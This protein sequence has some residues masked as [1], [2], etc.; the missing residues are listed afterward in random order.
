V[1]HRSVEVKGTAGQ[2]TRLVINVPPRYMESLQVSVLWPTWEWIQAPETRWLCAS[3]SESLS[4]K[5]SLDRRTVL[6]SAWYQERFGD[7]VQ[8]TVDQNE[9]TEYRNRRGG[10]MV[11]PSVGGSAT[12]KGGNRIVVD[13]PHNPL[14][15]ERDAQRQQ[16]IDFFLGTRSTRLDDKRRGAIVVVM[17]R[18]HHRDLAAVCRDHGYTVVRLPAECETPT[19]IVFPRSGR[20]V[21]RAVGDLLWPARE[22]APEIAAQ[23]AALGASAYAGQYQ[24]RPSPRGGGL[25]KRESWRFYAEGPVLDRRAQSWD[26]AFKGGDTHDCVVG[27]AAGQRGADVYL[28]DRFKAHA[29]FQR[30]C[31]AIQAW[32]DRYPGA[33]YRRQGQWA[34]GDRH[35][36]PRRAGPHRGGSGGRHVFAR[37]RGRAAGRGRPR[38]SATADD[39]DRDAAARPRVGRGLHRAIGR[40]SARRARR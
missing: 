25:F 39:P 16:A 30:T 15:A 29:S 1:F 5:H 17:Q 21:T 7:R 36:P 9:K 32:A 26:L 37:R 12:G 13:D 6:Q 24:P 38:L 28:I 14:Q 10:V 35:P 3:D 22:G 40:V 19:T 23:Q 33:I 11:A 27:L 31:A 4:T 34:S 18:L 8:L 2:V 20:T